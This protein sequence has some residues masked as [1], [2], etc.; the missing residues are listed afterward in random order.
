MPDCRG[1][2]VWHEL[3]TTDPAAARD[4]YSRLVGWST[5]IHEEGETPYTMWMDGEIPVGG[6]MELPPDARAGNVP[7]HWM[8]YIATPDVEE[9]TRKAEDLGATLLHGPHEI[10]E[11]GTFSVIQDPQGAVFSIWESASGEPAPEAPLRH[12]HFSWNELMTTDHEGAFDFYATLF[13]WAKTNAMDMGPLGTYQMYGLAD[14][15]FGGMY[16]K[17]PEVQAPP[18]WLHYVMVDDVDSAA[19]A[20]EELGGRILHG[21][22]DV[23]GGDRVVQCMDPQ[24]AVFA[25]HAKGSEG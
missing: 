10:P 24:G 5:S 14:R 18:H 20:V 16:N 12:G 9:T 1:A 11:M 2:F 15:T 4:F 7:P 3:M 8:A 19:R 17:P 22:Q 21:P 6:L 23:P 13:G 25:L